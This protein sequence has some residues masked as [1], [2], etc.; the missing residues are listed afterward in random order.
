MEVMIRRRSSSSSSS[1]SKSMLFIIK[2]I[3]TIMI[4]IMITTFQNNNNSHQKN[5]ILLFVLG[6]GLLNPYHHYQH[7]YHHTVISSSSSKTRQRRQRHIIIMNDSTIAHLTELLTMR[8]NKQQQQRHRHHRVVFMMMKNNN[9]DNDDDEI[10]DDKNS[11][12]KSNNNNNNNIEMNRKNNTI[13]ISSSTSS[14]D[15]LQQQQQQADPE[16]QQISMIHQ[17]NTTTTSNTTNNNN[18]FHI[19]QQYTINPIIKYLAQLSLYDYNWRMNIFQQYEA[20]RSID[21]S[22][23]SILGENVTYIR[24]MDAPTNI[25]GPLGQLEYNIVNTLLQIYREEYDRATLMIQQSGKIIR[26][27]E[28]NIYH[29][30]MNRHDDAHNNDSNIIQITNSSSSFITR[31]DDDEDSWVTTSLG[32]IGYLEKKVVDFIETIR[33]SETYR[34]ETKTARPKDIMPSS[35]RGPLG[36]LEYNI[37]SFVQDIYDSEKLRYQLNLNARNNNNIKN[38]KKFISIRPIDIPG[39]LGELELNVG[40]VVLAEKKRIAQGNGN[41]FMRPK[42]AIIKGPLGDIENIVSNIIEQFYIEEMERFKSIQIILYNSRPMEQNKQSL[43]GRIESFMVQIVRGPILLYHVL[44]R[45]KELLFDTQYLDIDSIPSSS[46]SSSLYHHQQYY[47]TKPSNIIFNIKNRDIK[48]ATI[49]STTPNTIYDVRNPQQQIH[50]QRQQ[51]KRPLHYNSSKIHNQQNNQ[52]Q[53]QQFNYHTTTDKTLGTMKYYKNMIY[54]S[55]PFLVLTTTAFVL[56]F[57]PPVS[58]SCQGA[59][60]SWTRFFGSSSTSTTTSNSATTTTASASSSSTTS[61]SNIQNHHTTADMQKN[62]NQHKQHQVAHE[63]SSQID[64]S[65]S[66]NNQECVSYGCLLKPIDVHYNGNENI[67]IAMERLRTERRLQLL[68]S[69]A[70]TQTLS[71][72]ATSESVTLTLIGYKG[73]SMNEQINQDRSIIVSPYTIIN[74]TTSTTTDETSSTSNQFIHLNRTLLGVFDGHAPLGE[75]VSEYTATTLPILLA[76]KLR[77][78]AKEIDLISKQQERVLKEINITKEIIEETFVELDKNAPADTSGGCTATII[79][80]Q[81][82]YIYIANA[83]DS[84]SFVITYRPSTNRSTV[85][86]ISREDKPSLSDEKERVERMGGQVYIPIRGTSR[87]VYHDPTTGAP[88]GLAMSRSIGDW[89]AGKLGVI[90]NPL[91]QVLNINTII[92]EQIYNDTQLLL[93]QNKNN[94]KNDNNDKS[95]IAEIDVNGNVITT[96]S[97]STIVNEINGDHDDTNNNNDDVYI[98]AVCATDGMMD[99]LNENDIAHVLGHSLYADDGAH[100]VAATEHLIF[101]AANSWHHAKHGRY[102]DD[103]AIAVSTLRK[104]PKSKLSKTLSTDK[105]TTPPPLS[106]L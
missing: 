16:R 2:L 9:E 21:T 66:N 55:A 58:I 97:S 14:Y 19:I 36:E 70:I 31:T 47:T 103:I 5:N 28:R 74:P 35:L 87:V 83:G 1:T 12:D 11:H 53:Q 24:P 92:H 44:I 33:V 104:P 102:R 32:P 101:S 73:G 37:T 71:N 68:K 22:M 84:R 67:K 20:S 82:E 94:N 86:A 105:T 6:F 61:N 38:K 98:F 42:D 106:K 75:L 91:I 69:D 79:L 29:T 65:D 93:Q 43:L 77:N 99:Y 27:I 51:Q 89:E 56:S 72:H 10:T 52:R 48:V 88:T 80:H 64:E 49:T 23:A 40:K 46:S 81:G 4:I 18:W 78:K 17:C 34:K 8:H 26:P 54:R 15:V 96:S 45:I 60:N 63:S 90:P 41:I 62:K 59:E 30:N 95:K 25:I 85:I 39:P 7:N 13:I 76:T 57:R 3:L 100:P 50:Q